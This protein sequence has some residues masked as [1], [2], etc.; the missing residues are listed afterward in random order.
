MERKDVR[1]Y[2]VEKE[3]GMVGLSPS[4]VL[5]YGKCALSFYFR[6]VEGKK[7]PP[8]ISL[9]KGSSYL[10]AAE[11][12]FVQK[13]KS[14]L[15]L[16]E[17]DIVEVAVA[18]FEKGIKEEEIILTEEEK[19]IGR[20][21]VI[22]KTKDAMVPLAKLYSKEVAPDY[23]P[24]VV[25]EA[26]TIDLTSKYFLFGKLDLVT[27]KNEIIDLKTGGKAKPADAADEDEQLDLY[28]LA[29][30]FKFGKLPA[31]VALDTAIQYETATKGLITRRQRLDSTRD[32]G[33]IEVTR[34]RTTLLLD[35]L[36]AEIYPP[37]PK[38]NWNC[39]PRWC[40]YYGPCFF[41]DSKG[42]TREHKGCPAVRHG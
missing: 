39:S 20:D 41:K 26:V 37:C 6:Y 5:M 13:I 12:N 38:G 31:K 33:H 3:K 17:K 22:G 1:K 10:S 8:G 36:E 7:I 9:K 14:G 28:T 15:D 32:K 19:A 24:V 42:N 34:N 25:E 35:A 2:D 29:Y 30:F 11:H 40:G 21:N 16:P 23:Q 18:S 4:Q 27:N